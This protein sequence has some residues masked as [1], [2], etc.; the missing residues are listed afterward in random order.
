MQE[1]GGEVGAVG[2]LDGVAREAV[3]DELVA[4]EQLAEYLARQVGLQVAELARAVAEGEQQ[5]VVLH[6]IYVCNFK[7]ICVLLLFKWLYPSQLL[8]LLSLL[9]EGEDFGLVQVHPLVH[10]GDDLRRGL[11]AHHAVEH[12]DG[13]L[14][15]AVGEVDMR[16][17]VVAPVEADDDSEEFTYFRHNHIAFICSLA[18]KVQQIPQIPSISAGKMRKSPIPSFI[19]PH[20]YLLQAVRRG[21]LFGGKYIFLYL[22]VFFVRNLLY[23]CRQKTNGY[24]K[25]RI[26]HQHLISGR[27]TTG[28]AV[29]RYEDL[30]N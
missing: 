6:I 7:H 25:T 10:L 8:A 12:A 28:T 27:G 3:L 9:P 30:W 22:F 21:G 4:V 17:V 26:H 16:R 24:K 2:P 20:Y 13:T 1:L 19:S 18:A 15:F 5:L 11:A 29:Q 23:L 14:V